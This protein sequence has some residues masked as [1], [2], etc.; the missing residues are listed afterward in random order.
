MFVEKF[1]RQWVRIALGLIVMSVFLTH[2][3]GFNRL[4]F[5]ERLEN[6]AYDAR[7]VLN[8]KGG[9]DDR[10]VIIDIDERSLAAEGRWPWGRDKIAKLV[11]NLFTEY[12]AGLL[13]FDVVF[14][15]PDEGSG[16]KVL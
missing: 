9:I 4:E 11:D 14:A 6:L 7:L 12:N 16:L 2:V 8:L 3:S 13:G 10:I 1:K 15:E 5:I